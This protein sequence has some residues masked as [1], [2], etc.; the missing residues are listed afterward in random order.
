[1]DRYYKIDVR[2]M[3]RLMIDMI[4]KLLDIDSWID[5]IR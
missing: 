4:D 2:D 3:S 1:M 5:S